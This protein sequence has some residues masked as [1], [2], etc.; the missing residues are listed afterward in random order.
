MIRISY[1]MENWLMYNWC[2][3]KKKTTTRLPFDCLKLMH[4]SLK[5]KNHKAM[6]S[7]KKQTTK[8]NILRN[9]TIKTQL[10]APSKNNNLK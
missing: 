4:E 6:I 10:K 9:K 5:T 8:A 3:Q 7:H 1:E 2:D